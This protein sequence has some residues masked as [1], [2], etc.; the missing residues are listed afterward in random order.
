MLG[1][2]TEF[3]TALTRLERGADRLAP[4]QDRVQ[5]TGPHGLAEGL[6]RDIDAVRAALSPP[7]NN[8]PAEGYVNR[9]KLPQRR[10]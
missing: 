4:W 1:R 6:S 5:A 2:H 8:G 9:V 10:I 3:A 7:R